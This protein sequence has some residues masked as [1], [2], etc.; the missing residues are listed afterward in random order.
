MRIGIPT[1]SPENMAQAYPEDYEGRDD[2]THHVKAKEALEQ[3][4]HNVSLFRINPKT[5]SMI[6]KNEF[7]VLLNFCDEGFDNNPLFEP[8]VASMLDLS[9]I[10]F[11]GSDYFTLA[12]CLNK[13]LTKKILLYHRIPTP[14]F[15]EFVTGDENLSKRLEFPLIV[16]PAQQDGSIG[17]KGDAVVRNE[18]Q[19]RER[20]KKI[21][22]HYKQPALVEE[23]IDGREFNVAILGN[24]DNI[25][26][27]PVSEIDFCDLSDPYEKIIS[28]DAKWKKDSRIYKKTVPVCPAKIDAELYADLVEMAVNAYKATGC[29]DYARVDFRVDA[30]GNPYVLEVNPNP[31]PSY[32]AGL[33]NMASK[34]GLSYGKLLERIIYTCLERNGVTR[35]DMPI[36]TGS[37]ASNNQTLDQH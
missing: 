18:A 10:P 7:D 27:L 28:Y 33:A 5:A 4:G 19:L 16:K 12:M 9:K 2:A 24:G 13:T 31:D 23:F 35:N 34:I 8:H 6:K 21:I 1:I 32:D 17:I 14:K 25:E 26:V 30:K 11:T 29:R 20:V 3:L 36:E 37:E 15:Q 22:S